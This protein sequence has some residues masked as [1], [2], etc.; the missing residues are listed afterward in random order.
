MIES[1]STDELIREL[2]SRSDL[3]FLIVARDTATGYARFAFTP[4]LSPDAVGWYADMGQGFATYLREE[5]H[6]SLDPLP[7]GFHQGMM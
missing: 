1:H 2:Q 7:D 6:D 3:R 4:G 5:L